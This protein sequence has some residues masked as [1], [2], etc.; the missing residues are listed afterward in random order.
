MIEVVEGQFEPSDAQQEL[1]DSVFGSYFPVYLDMTTESKYKQFCHT[2]MARNVIMNHEGH[3]LSPGYEPFK[4]LFMDICTKNNIKVNKILRAAVNN[5][6]NYPDLHGGIHI[7]HPEQ[8]HNNFIMYLNEFDNGHTYLFDGDHKQIYEI[9]P[10]K[11]KFA[12]FEGTPH[13]QGFCAPGQLRTVLV[14][15]FN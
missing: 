11:N 1:I 6:W 14:F 8:D 13:A 3:I 15:T 7:D 5:T 9:V 12:I 2:F 4:E 10:K